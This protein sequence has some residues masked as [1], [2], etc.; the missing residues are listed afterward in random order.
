LTLILRDVASSVSGF[1]NCRRTLITR[2]GC[3]SEKLIETPITVAH[4]TAFE[5]KKKEMY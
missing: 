4:S 3:L 2:G 1:N 5:K